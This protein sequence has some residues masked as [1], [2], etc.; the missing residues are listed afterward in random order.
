MKF[1]QRPRGRFN[2]SIYDKAR[3]KNGS[4]SLPKHRIKGVDCDRS[5]VFVLILSVCFKCLILHISEAVGGSEYIARPMHAWQ[6]ISKRLAD[7]VCV[8]K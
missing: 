1:T 2:C 8:A 3:Y 7:F 6:N 4:K 5:T